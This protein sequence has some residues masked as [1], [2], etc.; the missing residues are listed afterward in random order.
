MREAS[1]RTLI[2]QLREAGASVQA[3]DP[4]AMDE[5][6]RVFGEPAGLAFCDSAE[7]ALEGADALIVLTE[8]KQFRSPDFRLLERTLSDRVVFDG[9]N[10]Y[11]PGDVESM[12]LAYYAIGRGRSCASVS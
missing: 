3:Y 6:R 10:L 7:A 5:A 12:G 1:S 8:W 2:A 11:E 4:E 9:R